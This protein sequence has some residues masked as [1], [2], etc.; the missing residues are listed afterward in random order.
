MEFERRTQAFLTAWVESGAVSLAVGGSIEG[1]EAKPRLAV[2]GIERPGHPASSASVFDYASLTKPFVATLA[3]ILDRTGELRLKSRVSEFFEGVG[4]Q[5]GGRTLESLLRHRAGLPAWL[6]LARLGKRDPGAL[7]AR[8]ARLSTRSTRPRYSDMGYVLWGLVAEGALGRPLAEVLTREVLTPLELFSIQPSPG[9]RPGVA[10]CRCDGAKEQDLA[11]KLKLR[12]P[13][14]PPPPRGRPQDGNA[15]W[16]APHGGLCGHAGLFGNATDL[17]RFAREWL[18]PGKLLHAKE[19]E[20]ALSG[21][22]AYAMGWARR[23][24]RGSAGPALSPG[25]FGHTGFTGGS[26]W[27]D[28]TES[29]IHVLLAHRTDARSDLNPTRRA[30]HALADDLRR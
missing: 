16:L 23:R 17:L 14:G 8:L 5:L 15:R 12:I 2:S 1:G 20:R 18:H 7:A 26:L 29:R 10:R 24:V 30:F 28:P 6:P 3:L 21:R 9:A 19:V 22:G 13:V 11:R 25:A 4:P 27:I